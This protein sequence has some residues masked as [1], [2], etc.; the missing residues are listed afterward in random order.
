MGDDNFEVRYLR[1]QSEVK[2]L[3]NKVRQVEAEL[4][5]YQTNNRMLEGEL[6]VL[7]E[8]VNKGVFEHIKKL[9]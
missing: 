2:E 7:Q 8:Q 3:E 1:A 4:S 9:H 6:K 5:F